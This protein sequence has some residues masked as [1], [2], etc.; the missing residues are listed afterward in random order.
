MSIIDEKYNKLYDK[1]MIKEWIPYYTNMYVVKGSRN[2]TKFIQKMKKYRF[3]IGGTQ[4]SYMDFIPYIKDLMKLNNSPCQGC[5][6]KMQLLQCKNGCNLHIYCS[7]E[8]SN[9][10]CKEHE[11]ICKIVL[12]IYQIT[13]ELNISFDDALI[14]ASK[15]PPEP[16][17]PDVY[18]EPLI[19]RCSN[20]NCD[21]KDA[22]FKCSKCEA[23]YYCCVK[24]QVFD[25]K[26]HKKYCQKLKDI[27]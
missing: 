2:I 23:I 26:Y 17:Y 19:K 10:H 14:L 13:E 27:C 16:V 25:W 1:Y 5:G 22:K 21:I 24:C 4:V 18:F 7:E 9:N 12:K 6:K 15:D 20:L 11:S 3:M 8:C